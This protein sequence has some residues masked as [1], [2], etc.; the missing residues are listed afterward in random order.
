MIR[1]RDFVET[2]DGL[3]FAAVT[4][5]VVFLRYYPSATGGRMRGGVRYRKVSSTDEAVRYLAEHHREH[6][7]SMHGRVL[8]HCPRETVKKVH[9]PEEKLPLLRAES[10]ELARKAVTLSDLLSR[11]PAC[12][13]GITGSLLIGLESKG[14]DIDFVIYGRRN[15]DLARETLQEEAEELSRE[16][17][18]HVYRKRFPHRSQLGFQEFLWHERRKRNIG[19]IEGTVFN[20]LLVE[21]GVEPGFGVPVGEAKLRC[22]VINAKHGFALPSIYLVEH[23]EVRKIISYSHSYAGQALEGEEIEAKGVLE[24]LEGELMLVVGTSREA[25]GEY[26][27]VVPS[28]APEP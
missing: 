14:S 9:R 13:K 18:W 22:R 25:S 4:R 21:E 26:I 15:F 23:P 8:Q 1:P 16:E 27:R 12:C 24:A 3:L 5:D 19:K 11:I 2:M 7:F 28:D 20:L 17:W 10:G 6:I